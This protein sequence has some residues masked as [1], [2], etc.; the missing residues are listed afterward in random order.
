MESAR[1]AGYPAVGLLTGGI[2]G[3][4]LLRAGAASTYD[5]PAALTSALDDV[6]DLP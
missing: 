2:A 4:E 3:C 5:D 6:L 1:T